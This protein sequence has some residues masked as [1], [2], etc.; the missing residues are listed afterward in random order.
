VALSDADRERVV[1]ELTRHC[2]DGRLT[3][4]E[5]EER[6]GEAYAATTRDE[7]A[8]A[9]RELPSF[10]PEPAEPVRRTTRPGGAA[11]DVAAAVPT[12]ASRRA[13]PPAAAGCGLARMGKPPVLLAALIALLVVTAH[14]GW[15]ILV[16]L[17]FMPK[18][19][20][21]H[22]GAHRAYARS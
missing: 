9:L 2:G 21:R 6:V 22:R 4:D 11:E 13:G 3:L 12:P 10:R 19:L 20:N 14:I 5:L 1:R 7:L 8:L 17:V 16:F 15:A 18:H